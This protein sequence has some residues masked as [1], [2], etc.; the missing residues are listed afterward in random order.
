VPQ[1]PERARCKS[2]L[3]LLFWLL[4]LHG[5]TRDSRPRPAAAPPPP[6][7]L[8]LLAAWRAHGAPSTHQPSCCLA[9]T[10][11]PCKHATQWQAKGTRA[12]GKH[13]A[14][15]VG[16]RLV[17]RCAP[18]ACC[19]A[20]AHR[21]NPRHNPVTEGS[22]TPHR[23]KQRSTGS[24]SSAAFMLPPGRSRADW[25]ASPIG[26]PRS[27]PLVACG[28]VQCSASGEATMPFRT[29]VMRGPSGPELPAAAFACRAGRP[30]RGSTAAMPSHVWVGLANWP[31]PLPTIKSNSVTG[32]CLWG[33]V[34]A[35]S[36]DVAPVA[37]SPQHPTTTR[38]GRGIKIRQLRAKHAAAWAANA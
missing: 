9:T 18:A 37:G 19:W 4:P 34:R 10:S 20:A 7:A 30:G 14:T 17:P 36:A 3:L 13:I 38:A 25:L 22:H 26:R 31:L 5:V 11:P 33:R 8:V 21:P 27:L 2:L 12:G 23:P 29:A 32:A 28:S 16:R 24:P 35:P 15:P 6:P 1:T